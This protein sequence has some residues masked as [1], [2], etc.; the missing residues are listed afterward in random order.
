MTKSLR[1]HRSRLGWSQA[2]LARESGLN[3]TTVALIDKGRLAPYPI[4][5]KKLCRALGIR[6]GELAES[7]MMKEKEKA[8]AIGNR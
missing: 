8:D 4:Q 6:E 3:Q 5:A 1:N 7:K 2:R